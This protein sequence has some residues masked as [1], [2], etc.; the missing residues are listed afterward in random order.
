MII[1]H[2]VFTNLSHKIIIFLGIFLICLITKFQNR[3]SEH[4]HGL[5]WIKNA[6]L[7]GVH[8]N[9]KI[10]RFIDMYIFYDV[11]LLPNPLQNAQQHQHT[12][13]CKKKNH[14]VCRFHYPLPSMRETKN[15]EPLQMIGNYPFSDQYLIHKQTKYF[16]I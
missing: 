5:L 6:P 10:E 9:E 12:C 7:Y 16:N 15:L 11:S 2:I 14:V 13:T 8:T 4:D 3:G 1:K